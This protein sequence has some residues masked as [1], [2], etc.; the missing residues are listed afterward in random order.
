M[1]EDIIK[2][3]TKKRFSIF[4][5]ISIV[6]LLINIVLSIKT[7][8]DDDIKINEN[9]LK[10]LK[11]SNNLLNFELNDLEKI[12]LEMFKYAVPEEKIKSDVTSMC[13]SFKK[14][15]IVNECQVLNI[16]SPFEY[17]NVSSFT[18]ASSYEVDRLIIDRLFKQIYN[19]KKSTKNDWGV[20]FEIYNKIK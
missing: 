17:K 5:L 20:D 19:T 8:E 10:H 11:D 9:K 6:L 14:I 16:V 2:E 18:I 1:F 12:N 3:K 4:I 13:Q 7:F 15:G